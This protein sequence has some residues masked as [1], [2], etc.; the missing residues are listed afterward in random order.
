MFA[1]IKQDFFIF[2]QKCNFLQF[3][4]APK[5]RLI[6]DIWKKNVKKMH[7]STKKCCKIVKKGV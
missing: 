7:F 4:K 1:P 6:R 3:V 2:N 5:I